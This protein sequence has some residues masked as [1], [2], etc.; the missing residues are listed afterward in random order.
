M[1]FQGLSEPTYSLQIPP[2]AGYCAPILTIRMVTVGGA[3]AIGFSDLIRSLKEGKIADVIVLGHGS[4][5]K[6][7][8]KNN[9]R[10]I[11]WRLY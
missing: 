11:P 5:Q 2:P 7:T 8:I 4:H 10:E 6:N 1:R 9:E 3:K